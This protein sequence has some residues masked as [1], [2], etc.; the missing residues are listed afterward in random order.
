VLL[1]PAPPPAQHQDCDGCGCACCQRER[2]IDRH[3][4]ES[5][6]EVNMLY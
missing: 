4:E 1:A 3:C 2:S 5:S 6:L